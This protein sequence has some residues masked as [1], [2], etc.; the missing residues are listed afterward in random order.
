MASSASAGGRYLNTSGFLLRYWTPRGGAG[1]CSSSVLHHALL[2]AVSAARARAMRRRRRLAIRS[3]CCRLGQPAER[4]CFLRADL[5]RFAA[6]LGATQFFLGRV[7]AFSP[8]LRGARPTP[9]AADKTRRRIVSALGERRRRR[10]IAADCA[11]HDRNHLFLQTRHWAAAC[12]RAAAPHNSTTHIWNP[13]SMRVDVLLL[14]R[15]SWGRS[16]HTGA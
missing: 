4:H 9:S 5:Q 2:P 8:R 12:N 13:T 10:A 11:I 14:L 1:S 3:T 6:T 16:W 15:L 7:L